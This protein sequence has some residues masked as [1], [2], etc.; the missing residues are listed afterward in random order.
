MKQLKTKELLDKFKF[1][2]RIL[3]TY[4]FSIIKIIFKLLFCKQSKTKEQMN[5]ILLEKY[6]HPKLLIE[7]YVKVFPVFHVVYNLGFF[8]YY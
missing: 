4:K 5:L 2:R 8:E 7:N 6:Q 3:I 1:T